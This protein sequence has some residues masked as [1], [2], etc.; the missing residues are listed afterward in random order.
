MYIKNV[1]IYSHGFSI[2]T[3]THNRKYSYNH[4]RRQYCG[5][6]VSFFFFKAAPKAYGGSQARGQIRAVTASLHHGHSNPRSK[7]CLPPTPQ[8]M[9]AQDPYPTEQGQELK[10]QPHGYQLD[11]FPMSQDG[12]SNN[13]FK[14]IF[15]ATLL[16]IAKMA[17][18]EVFKVT[19]QISNGTQEQRTTQPIKK[20]EVI[21]KFPINTVNY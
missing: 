21:W 18:M 10:L 3:F 4:R 13:V 15:I 16:I 2:S 19:Y 5:G 11:S 9:A 20:N 1:N 7:L 6:E 8:L 17:T 14:R 12:N